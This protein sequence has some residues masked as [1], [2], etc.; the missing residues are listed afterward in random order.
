MDAVPLAL[1]Q[2][3]SGTE[4]E[5]Q[6]HKFRCSECNSYL[7]DVKKVPR[8]PSCIFHL[9]CLNH[10]NPP[11]LF[12]CHKQS[13]TFTLK[14]NLN[15]HIYNAACGDDDENLCIPFLPVFEETAEDED[16]VQPLNIDVQDIED[17]TPLSP[18]SGWASFDPDLAPSISDHFING[19][20]KLLSEQSRTYF[21]NEHSAHGN[22]GVANL[23]AN[24][25]NYKGSQLPSPLEI[26]FHLYVTSFL[27]TLTSKQT[28]VFATIIGVMV[29]NAIEIGKNGSC[30]IFSS[31]VT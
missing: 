14:K 24:T 23:V 30:E 9:R 6:L 20:G 8:F 12:V 16:D 26:Y 18:F 29:G 1:C 7:V 25:F 21:A 28:D 17:P 3:I 15:R 13:T 2:V 31:Q 27:M 4:M 10:H 22:H 19:A 11:S 5:F